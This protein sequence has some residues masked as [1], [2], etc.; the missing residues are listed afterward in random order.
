MRF[1]YFFITVLTMVVVP[2]SLI[3]QEI[4][5]LE[6]KPVPDLPSEYGVTLTRSIGEYDGSGIIDAVYEK[7]IVIND[8]G[9]SFTENIQ[10]RNTRGETVNIARLTPGVNVY[11]FLESAGKIKALVLNN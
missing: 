10:I 2:L 1:F 4:K 3:A 11:Y 7:R 8:Q 5:P 6:I 9:F